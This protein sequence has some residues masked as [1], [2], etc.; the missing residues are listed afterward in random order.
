MIIHT[1]QFKLKDGLSPAEVEDFFDE[2]KLLATIRGT[3]NFQS[4][5]QVSDKNPFSFCFS[6]EFEDQISYEYYSNH[7]IHS[8]FLERQ[9]CPKVASFQEADFSSFDPGACPSSL[10]NT[11]S[12]Q[13][14]LG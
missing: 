9:W 4:Y 11:G 5:L 10:K 2:A 3:N 13:D 7:S 12:G 14:G 1:V 6:M 8:D